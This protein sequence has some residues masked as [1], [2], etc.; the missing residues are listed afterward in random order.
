MKDQLIFLQKPENRN[1]NYSL[2]SKWMPFLEAR[3]YARNLKLQSVQEW[4]KF[5]KGEISGLK[6]PENI[7]FVP[8]QFYK[9][10]GWAGF[11]DWLGLKRK[12][13][14]NFHRFSFARNFVRSLQLENTKQWTL[15]CK[16]KLGNRGVKP[17][18]IPTSPDVVYAD[19]GWISWNDWFGCGVVEHNGK[20]YEPFVDARSFIRSFKFTNVD[21]WY[22]YCHGE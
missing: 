7:P 11:V 3:E 19:K 13:K 8:Q 22:Q 9:Y 18:N 15:Y 4:I 6:K 5:A 20:M 12:K 21:Q 10:Q 17:A 16:G 1:N 2:D 14:I